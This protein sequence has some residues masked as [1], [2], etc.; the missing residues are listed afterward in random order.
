MIEES[1]TWKKIGM[2]AGPV[3]FGVIYFVVPTGT[4]TQNA[5]TVIAL[6]S[7]MVAWWV[8]EAIPIPATALLP[9]I[10][11]PITGATKMS[12]VAQPYGDPVIFLF[13]GGFILALGL[14]KYNLHQRIALSLIR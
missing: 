7:W 5:I 12:E 10:V 1:I 13:M 9:L 14:E 2:V 6:G 4:L 3:L 11:L 8:T